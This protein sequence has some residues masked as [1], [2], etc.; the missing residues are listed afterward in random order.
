MDDQPLNFT[1]KTF[2]KSVVKFNDKEYTV[3]VEN[4]PDGWYYGEIEEI[5]DC[6][7]YGKTIEELKDNLKK[8]IELCLE[9]DERFFVPTKKMLK[10]IRENEDS[11][12]YNENTDKQSNQWLD[13]DLGDNLS[14]WEWKYEI[15]EGRTVKYV[16]DLGLIY[17]D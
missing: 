8:Y 11:E 5:S 16:K 13:S 9:T 10:G 7:S 1:N 4:L 2:F 15:P 3:S 12:L 14:Q 6:R 17:C